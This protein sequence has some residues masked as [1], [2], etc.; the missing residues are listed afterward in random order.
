[1]PDNSILRSLLTDAAERGITYR[2]EGIERAVAPSSEAIG[3]VAKF[4]EPMP[5]EGTDEQAVLSI[6]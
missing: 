4:V 2:E 6:Y 3:A 5:K 1:M